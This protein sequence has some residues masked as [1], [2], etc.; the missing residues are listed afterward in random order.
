MLLSTMR[1]FFILIRY[2]IQINSHSTY[3]LGPGKINEGIYVVSG[4]CH[5]KTGHLNID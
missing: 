3:L 2:C 4:K 1:F 5:S